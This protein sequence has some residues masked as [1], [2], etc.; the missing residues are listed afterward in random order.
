MPK[1][2]YGYSRNKVN[3]FKFIDGK[4]QTF[5]ALDLGT[6]SCRLIIVGIDNNQ[7]VEI[8]RF[9]QMVNLGE[10]LYKTGF[11]SD[12]AID[13]CI[14]IFYT[15][16]RKIEMY[17]PKKIRCVATEAC[18]LA[19]NTSHLVERIQKEAYLNLEII[20]NQEE[21]KLA[22]LGCSELFQKHKEKI[23]VIDIGGG[24]IEL[25]FL[26]NK[27]VNGK[28]NILNSQ[29]FPIGVINLSE[30]FTDESN[31]QDYEKMLSY[32]HNNLKDFLNNVKNNVHNK[33]KFDVVSTSGTSTTLL[34]IV[35]KMI[36]YDRDRIDGQ[37]I[38]RK[39]LDNAIN[40]IKNMNLE[41]K[42]KSPLIGEH[43]A[44]LVIPGCAIMEILYNE[45]QLEKM[46]VADRGVRDGIIIEMLNEYKLKQS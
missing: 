38:S 33:D 21:A 41:D 31:Q 13:R 6:S 12:T 10:S 18:R 28:F 22:V 25:I 14:D 19:G 3:K 7:V 36:K 43:R 46:I 45:L 17:N 2:F 11:L 1:T 29:S 4:H 15:C 42:K 27:M 44:N 24:S 39:N 5:A 40:I 8:E 23:L 34:A 16:Q 35:K 32:I 26:E 37:Q 30:Q 20:S 9:S